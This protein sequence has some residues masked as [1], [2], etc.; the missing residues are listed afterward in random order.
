[1][2]AAVGKLIFQTTVGALNPLPVLVLPEERREHFTRKLRRINISTMGFHWKQDQAFFS[3][4]EKIK[5]AF[6]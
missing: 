1:V 4:L 6:L 3:G 2:L 5:T